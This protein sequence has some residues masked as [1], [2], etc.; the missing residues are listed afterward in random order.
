VSWVV[1][2]FLS[3]YWALRC[4]LWV[5]GQ[6]RLRRLRGTLPG[7]PVQRVVPVH[8]G[9]GLGGLLARNFS[10]RVELA[11]STRT[12]AEVLITDPDV[13][14]GCVRDFRYRTALAGAWRAACGW[15]QALE[16]L[17]EEDRGALERLGYNPATFRQRHAWLDQRVRST[18]RAPALEPFEV[19]AVE[20]S[21]QV[22][23]AMIG[24]LERL[25]H[26]LVS[27]AAN[28]YRS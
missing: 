18:V 10:E 20:T 26:A 9:A 19:S 5:R 1:F 16:S 21:R 11:A 17:A 25:E 7:R 15:L 14:L 12:M 27:P 24:E 23:E 2:M 6:V 28:P 3:S 4:V 8:L 13:P 22:V